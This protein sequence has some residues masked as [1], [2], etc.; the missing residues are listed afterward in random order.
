MTQNTHFHCTLKHHTHFLPAG[1]FVSHSLRPADALME[2]T[3]IR[4]GACRVDGAGAPEPLGARDSTEIGLPGFSVGFLGAI[5]MEKNEMKETSA[6]RNRAPAPAARCG[7]RSV[8]YGDRGGLWR[9]DGSAGQSLV[10]LVYAS[11]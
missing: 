11:R 2:H 9:W 7:G 6:H 5:L 10:Q 8:N 1:A 3:I 4:C